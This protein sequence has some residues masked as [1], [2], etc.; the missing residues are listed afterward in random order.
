MD[1]RVND[2][3]IRGWCFLWRV[4]FILI[5]LSFLLTTKADFLLHSEISWKF[6]EN[7]FDKIS[8]LNGLF[9]VN[10]FPRVPL[11]DRLQD[12]INKQNRERFQH[13]NSAVRRGVFLCLMNRDYIA[14]DFYSCTWIEDFVYKLSD[15]LSQQLLITSDLSK[16]AI[17]TLFD[18][19][20]VDN[21]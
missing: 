3:S 1:W 9:C 13:Q 5:R 14:L 19:V 8:N 6:A 20:T 11:P 18:S 7:K 15:D 17:W 2:T 10:R 12:S 16:E 21:L 4:K